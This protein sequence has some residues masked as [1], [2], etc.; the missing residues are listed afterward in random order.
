[1]KRIGPRINHIY[2]IIM[3][4]GFILFISMFFLSA[5]Y[6]ETCR[7][8]S[9]VVVDNTTARRFPWT[10]EQLVSA[11]T[12]PDSSAG[13]T[14]DRPGPIPIPPAPAG[15]LGT[16]T[17]K[18]KTVPIPPAPPSWDKPAGTITKKKYYKPRKIPP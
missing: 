6:A 8:N 16:G 13:Q 17:P 11:D 3:I 2:F 15:I 9:N 7:G 14:T 10:G 1:M 18:I 5:V 12:G 4:L